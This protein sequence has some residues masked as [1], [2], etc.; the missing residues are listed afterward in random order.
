MVPLETLYAWCYAAREILQGPHLM[1]RVIARPFTGTP[2]AFRRL[3][4][5]RKDLAVA[6]P[7]ESVL[8]AL[9]RGG[10]E[11]VAIGKIDDIFSG[12]GVTRKVATADDMDGVDATVTALLG[13]AWD[14]PGASF[15]RKLV[16]PPR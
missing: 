9:E 15:A 16:T 1:A 5:H 2:G 11:V 14:G 6:P 7:V 8:D 3:G 4:E 13:V 10:R 12:Q